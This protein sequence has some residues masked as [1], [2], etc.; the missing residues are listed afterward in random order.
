MT[1]FESENDRDAWASLTTE[2]Y[3]YTMMDKGFTASQCHRLLTD[4]LLRSER[5]AKIHARRA[6]LRIVGDGAPGDG[7]V[8]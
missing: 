6:A 3:F 8:T 4:A 7:A 5:A 1:E 2:K